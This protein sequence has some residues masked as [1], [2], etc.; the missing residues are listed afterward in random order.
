MLAHLPKKLC[1]CI[2]ASPEAGQSHTK[3]F[4]R[5]LKKGRTG[6]IK[7]KKWPQITISGNKGHEDPPAPKEG[8]EARRIKDKTEDDKK[9]EIILVLKAGLLMYCGQ[10]NIYNCTT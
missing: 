10:K 2:L 8:D 3:G 4:T 6:A 1:L 7:D 5:I 9:N